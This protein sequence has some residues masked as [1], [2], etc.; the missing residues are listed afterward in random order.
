MVQ[1]LSSSTNAN[2][3]LLLLL[4]VHHDYEIVR[5]GVEQLDCGPFI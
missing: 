3:E 5:S 4:R 1:E 2:V